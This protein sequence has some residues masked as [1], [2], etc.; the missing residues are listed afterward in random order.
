[1]ET[2]KIV[3][4]VAHLM[5]QRTRLQKDPNRDAKLRNE[6]VVHNADQVQL[7]NTASQYSQASGSQYPYEKDQSMKVERLKTLVQSGNYNMDDPVIAAIAGNI[8]KML[9]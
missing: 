5:R 3:S 7:T 9:L 6:P 4:Q 2:S 1:M 8:A